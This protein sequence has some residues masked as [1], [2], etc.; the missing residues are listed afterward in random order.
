MIA[1][2]FMSSIAASFMSSIAILV[3]YGITVTSHEHQSEYLVKKNV[4]RS[5]L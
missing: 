5:L 1:T 2:S 4:T 3:Y